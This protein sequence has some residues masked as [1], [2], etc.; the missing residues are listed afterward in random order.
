MNTDER[1]EYTIDINLHKENNEWVVEAF[2][3]DTLEKIHGIY[4][5]ER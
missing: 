4:N 5:Y 1:V 3:K 2:D